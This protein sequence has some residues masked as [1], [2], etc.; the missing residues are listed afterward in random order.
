MY[1]DDI[2]SLA[3]NIYLSVDSKKGKAVELIDTFH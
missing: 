3:N 2:Q 1:V